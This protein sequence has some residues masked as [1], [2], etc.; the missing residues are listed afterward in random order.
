MESNITTE[1]FDFVVN[2]FVKFINEVFSGNDETQKTKLIKKF[3]EFNTVA[4]LYKNSKSFMPIEKLP[5]EENSNLK[6]RNSIDYTKMAD[7]FTKVMGT[8][9]SLYRNS[10]TRLPQNTQLPN[11]IW[12]KILNHLT[13]KD[14][15]GNFTLVCKRFNG[16]TMDS[17]T[18]KY[19]RL[20]D[21]KTNGDT[22][23]MEKAL[24]VL[25]RCH[26]L[27]SLSMDKCCT[28]F[29]NTFAIQVFQSCSRLKSLKITNC[30]RICIEF[31]D[32]EVNP[33]HW[34]SNTEEENFTLL[35]VLKQSDIK[36]E[37]FELE[38][39]SALNE[40]SNE[41]IIQ[42]P[43]IMAKNLKVLKIHAKIIPIN[44]TK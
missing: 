20:S 21:F 14:I 36:L 31:L 42:I 8:L 12:I 17:G 41:E 2:N 28:S 33:Y 38:T 10:E 9:R 39:I 44:F 26:F 5:M 6:R 7:D 43:Q 34:F 22:S 40:R 32:L 3:E 18:I 24:K 16:F 13:T 19:I 11:E 1:N 35:D 30:E 37:N 4:T 27:K 29:V 25:K 23:K 15:F